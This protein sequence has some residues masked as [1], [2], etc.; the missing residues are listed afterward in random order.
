[1]VLASESVDDTA[2]LWVSSRVLDFGSGLPS[3]S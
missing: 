3:A 1:M 2:V